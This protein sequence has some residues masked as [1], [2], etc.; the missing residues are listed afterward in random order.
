MGRGL[1]EEVEKRADGQGCRSLA[2]GVSDQVSGAVPAD[3]QF[4]SEG[5]K[6]ST[7]KVG[8]GSGLPFTTMDGMAFRR[9]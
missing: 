5:E 6:L 8:M 3:I 4:D 9:Y 2:R 7:Q 1:L